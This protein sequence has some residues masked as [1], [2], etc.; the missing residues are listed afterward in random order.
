MTEEMPP[1]QPPEKKGIHWSHVTMIVLITIVLTIGGTYWALKTFVFIKEFE[2]VSLNQEEE[3]I[4]DTK[5]EAIGY[6]SNEFDS[7]GRLKPQP[8]SEA[9]ASRE[10]AFN[11]RE[12]NALLAKNTDLARKVAI[13]LSD[14]LISAKILI[15][16]EEDF[17]ILGG[18]TLRVNAGLEVA[19]LSNRPKVILK[20]VSVMGVPVP[21]AWLGG[22]KNIDLV[23]EY[24]EGDG[25]WKAFADGVSDIY[26]KE[27]EIR[28]HLKE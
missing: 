20:G 8:Y 6:E 17:P 22:I 7:Q 4:L 11:E 9:G 24:G 18:Q 3:K 25:F 27:G 16:M 23:N 26:V 19:Y 14:D 2:P 5:L 1:G 10:V 13:D 15:P 28:V 12:L 21:S